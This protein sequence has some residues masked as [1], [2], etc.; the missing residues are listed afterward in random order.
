MLAS[1]PPSSLFCLSVTTVPACIQASNQNIH[2]SIYNYLYRV[3]SLLLTPI[4][5][6]PES[7]ETKRKKY[8]PLKP[9]LSNV[10]L[11]LLGFGAGSAGGT[12]T[13]II[14]LDVL[15]QTTKPPGPFCETLIEICSLTSFGLIF[16][17]PSPYH[18]T[19]VKI[20]TNHSSICVPCSSLHIPFKVVK[21][22]E[23]PNIEKRSCAGTLRVCGICGGLSIPKF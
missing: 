2:T 15:R 5:F 21:L 16:L 8:S 13:A 11:G 14:S 17:K 10:F 7:V 1:E 9:P 4:P 12:I 23:L 3:F 20:K 18:Q 19:F 22:F 6:L